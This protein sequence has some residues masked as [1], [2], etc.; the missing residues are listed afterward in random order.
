MHA[1]TEQWQERN[2]IHLTSKLV[3]QLQCF[4]CAHSASQQPPPSRPSGERPCCM[5]VRNPGVREEGPLKIHERSC[6]ENS[7]AARIALEAA[8]RL[9]GAEPTGKEPCNCKPRYL[10][11]LYNGDLADEAVVMD[12]YRTMEMREQLSKAYEGGEKVQTRAVLHLLLE[13][14]TKKF[15]KE[16]V[17]ELVVADSTRRLLGEE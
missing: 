5:C 1:T 4:G 17:R 8:Q 9:G 10:S 15:G 13:S 12:N 7:A 16:L 11:P 14:V 2:K 6:P 3:E